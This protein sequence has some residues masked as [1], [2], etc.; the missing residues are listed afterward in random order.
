MHVC[1]VFVII[2]TT[3]SFI[4]HSH[5][6]LFLFVYACLYACVCVCVVCM[7]RSVDTRMYACMIL[8]SLMHGSRHRTA[9]LPRVCTICDLLSYVHKHVSVCQSQE[10]LPRNAFPLERTDREGNNRRS[11]SVVVRWQFVEEQPSLGKSSRRKVRPKGVKRSSQRGRAREKKAASGSLD[12]SEGVHAR[13]TQAPWAGQAARRF[14]KNVTYYRL[15]CLRKIIVPIICWV[16]SETLNR[17]CSTSESLSNLQASFGLISRF[18]SIAH[19][20]N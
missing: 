17:Q 14:S 13:V 6:S 4:R 8:L 19:R 12:V 1:R 20:Y 7:S 15:R 18:E 10:L 2:R 11:R 9:T 16:A 3:L 5:F